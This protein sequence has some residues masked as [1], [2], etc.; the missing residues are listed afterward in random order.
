MANEYDNLTT[1]KAIDALQNFETVTLFNNQQ[2]EVAQYDE[3]LQGYQSASIATER[4]AATLNA[5]QSVVLSLGVTVALVISLVVTTPGK[6]T[7]GDLVRCP[8]QI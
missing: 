5:G 8:Q 7:P 3:Y 6:V 4:V 2:L 1:G